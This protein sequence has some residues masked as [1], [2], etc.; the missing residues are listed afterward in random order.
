M[1]QNLN[2]ISNGAAI[3]GRTKR[4]IVW[5]FLLN[6]ALAWLGASALK[7]DVA[8]ITD[9][10][11]FA[12][13]IVHGM[14][15]EALGELFGRPEMGAQPGWATPAA[16]FALLFFLLTLVFLPGVLQGYASDHRLPRD[17]FFRACG[18][19]VWRFFR[20]LIFFAI[21]GGLVSGILF[22]VQGALAKALDKSQSNGAIPFAVQIACLF[23]IFVV[24][25]TIR[26]WFDLAETDIVLSDQNASRKS[27][28][29]AWRT[30]R[31]HRARLVWAYALITL[32]AAIVLVVGILLWNRI[33]P[34]ASVAG[35]FI[36][37]QLI[38][39]FWLT[40][41]FW[42][43]AAAVSFYLAQ[44]AGREADVAPVAPVLAA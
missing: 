8:A 26:A 19:N 43:R 16:H 7:M 17:A 11:L 15:L 30:M 40:A 33:V 32:L 9:H 14:D 44:G 41:R 23:V 25:T 29:F 22:A 3:L 37:S 18:R 5:F 24:M 10:S 1:A 12:D 39:L 20:L 6:L 28:G 4:Y 35:A 34:P 2:L 42:Q 27:L 38:L 36:I 13:K 31:G 21:I